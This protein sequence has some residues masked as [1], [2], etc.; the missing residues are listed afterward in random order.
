M[1]TLF[2]PALVKL[3]AEREKDMAERDCADFK[4]IYTIPLNENAR[5]THPREKREVV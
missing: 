2:T 4:D 3:L 5:S 1:N